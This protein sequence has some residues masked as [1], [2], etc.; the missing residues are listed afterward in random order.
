MTSHAT[1]RK[2]RLGWGASLL[3]VTLLGALPESASALP[4][5]FV[6]AERVSSDFPCM[7]CD[8]F[9]LPL[10]APDDIAR[11]RAIIAGEAFPAGVFAKIVAGA[12]GINRD[13]LAPGEPLWSWHVTEFFLFFEGFVDDPGQPVFFGGSP[14]FVESDVAGWIA[15][16]PFPGEEGAGLIAFQG[17]TVVA[18]V[19]EPGSLAL[20]L[21]GLVALA[22]ARRRWAG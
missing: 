11:A 15:L 14:G 12:D 7:E 4:V 2:T 6:V 17:Y 22:G 5:F 18:E 9:I 1:A 10:S 19:P 20:A 21:V 8:S 13:I 3:V 16:N